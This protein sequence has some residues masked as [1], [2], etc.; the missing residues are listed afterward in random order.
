MG[1]VP[2]RLTAEFAV[3]GSYTPKPVLGSDAS[4]ILEQLGADRAADDPDP[5]DG[6]PSEVRTAKRPTLPAPVQRRIWVTDVIA[7]GWLSAA[8]ASGWFE[9]QPVSS[10]AAHPDVVRV[11]PGESIRKVASAA[12]RPSP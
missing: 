4:H 8:A 6:P 10:P 7:E 2:R 9:E 5:R 11:A 12:T 3:I 1:S